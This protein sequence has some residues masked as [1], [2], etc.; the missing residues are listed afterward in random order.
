MEFVGDA[1]LNVGSNR[2][3][4][5]EYIFTFT[6]ISLN[7]Y[8]TVSVVLTS[9]IAFTKSVVQAFCESEYDIYDVW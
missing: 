1:H 6:I 4:F 9:T 5:S 2:I 8:A 7:A 3:N